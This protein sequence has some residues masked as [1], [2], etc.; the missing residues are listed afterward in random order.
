VG[1]NSLYW[2]NHDQPR[3]V[4]RWGDDGEHRVASAKA[5]ATV[6]HLLRGTPYVFQG[7]ELGM[8]NAGFTELDS[9][10]DI[11][12]V[13]YARAARARGIDE[14]HVL[15]SLAVKSRD[16]ARTPVQWDATAHAGFTTGTPWLAVNPNHTEINAQAA[17]ADPDSVFHHYRTLISLRH[18]HPVVVHGD[19]V[20]VLPA[21]Q[22]VFAYT[23]THGDSTLL[24]LANLS[25]EPA[26]V[27][28]GSHAELL[29][30]TVLLATAAGGSPP[31]SRGGLVMGPWEA[32]AVLTDVRR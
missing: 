4:S 25:G 24:V 17:L 23:R 14:E 26:E 2:N 20:M 27:D 22:Q 9:Y 5:W 10:R 21:H 8:T 7:E 29:D 6:L 31:E 15:R 12:A 3:I 30:G 32:R 18:S 16:N 1:W 13:N 19:V 11:E 28:L